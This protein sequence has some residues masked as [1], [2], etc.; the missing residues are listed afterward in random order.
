MERSAT[1]LPFLDVT[2]YKT[3]TKIWMDI[4]SKPADL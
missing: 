3:A 1:K 2:V 4:F